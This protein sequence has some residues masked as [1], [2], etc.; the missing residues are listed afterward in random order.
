MV[1]VVVIIVV[2]VVAWLVGTRLYVDLL[3]FRETGFRKVFTTVLGTR[4]L[5]FV[6]GGLLLGAAV[7]V[8]V[9]LAYRMRPPFRPTSLEQQNLDRYRSALGPVRVPLLI[10]VV[11]LAVL[12]GGGAAQTHWQTW[13]LWRHGHSFGHVDPQF[14]RD[15]SYYAF[16]YPLERFILGA[17]FHAVLLAILVSAVTHYL[18][19]GIRLQTPGDKAVPAAKA[20]LSVLLGLLV[21]LK[22]WAYYLDR[23]GLNFSTRGFVTNGA[24]YTDINIVLPAKLVLLAISIVCAVLFFANVR[25]RGWTLPAVSLGLLVFA[26]VVIGGIVPL[27]VQ[28][29]GVKPNEA[30]K[31]Q[32]YIARNIAETQYAYK[33]T[34]GDV[35]TETYDTKQAG[36]DQAARTSAAVNEDI[37]LLDPMVLG[38][39]FEQLQQ[40]KNYYGFAPQLDV[41]RYTTASGQLQDYVVAARE[42]DL[43]GLPVGSQSWI[44]THLVYTHGQGFVAAQANTV[45][46]QGQPD[47]STGSSDLPETGPLAAREAQVYF[48]EKSPAY[49][50]VDT[51]TKEIDGAA[52]ETNSY[53]GTGGVGIGGLLR[54]AVFATRFGDVN[55]LLNSGLTSSS[56]ILYYRSPRDRVQKVAPWLTVDRNPYP[57]VVG[58]RLIWIV[59]GYTT[60]DAFP[61]SAREQLSSAT[62]DSTQ[63][64]QGTQSGT[65]NYIRNSVKAVVDAEDGSVTLYAVDPSDPILQTWMSTFP[66]TVQPLSA[67]SD[68][69]REHFRYPQDLFEVQRQLLARYYVTDPQTFYKQT[70]SYSVPADPVNPAAGSQPPFYLVSQVPGQQSRQFNLVSTYNAL[71]RPNLEAYVSVSSGPG[72]GADPQ[73]AYGHITLLQLPT[74]GSGVEQVHNFFTTQTG[75][76]QD[77]SLFNQGNSRVQEGNLLTLPVNGDF[78]Y[79]EPVY[80]TAGS[81]AFPKLKAVLASYKGRLGYSLTLGGA[82]DQAVLGQPGATNQ[83]GSALNGGTTPAPA[84]SSSAP[85]VSSAAP[86]SA[87]PTPSPSGSLTVQ[88][89]IQSLLQQQQMINQQLQQLLPSI[90]GS[91]SAAAAPS[92]GSATTPPV[93]PTASASG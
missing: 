51:K 67:A 61:Y 87:P 30:S 4:V 56:K 40:K 41:D 37:R 62:S 81:Q 88:Q 22:A 17:L 76:T 63:Q 47:F 14:H 1:P 84:P 6:L 78:L 35:T 13:L 33:L 90:L 75:F 16:T 64:Q 5:L 31:E 3:F 58:G 23:F 54:K 70:A 11:A 74:E 72:D 79:V 39:T 36:T 85:P 28:Q 32:P 49:S 44:N 52:N 68:E 10:V 59:D 25:L 29:L 92:S 80:L 77:E 60:T 50:V 21:L 20:H 48:G 55:L 46:S 57:A 18:W 91:A 24:S 53:A 83:L 7:G 42:V 8:N 73:S 15:V 12:L 43:G 86:T 38:P 9:Y 66:G 71:S 2:L 93:T 34:K 69:L 19:G 45:D 26:S 82:L 27:L 89:Q 65:V